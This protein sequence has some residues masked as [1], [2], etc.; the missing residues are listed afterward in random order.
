MQALARGRYTVERTLGSGGM[1]IVY[2]ARDEELGRPVAIKVLDE[3]FAADA[4]FRERFVR[5][6]R[7]A[8]RL[9]HPNIVRV[10]DVGEEDGQPYIVMEC[11][12]GTTLADE[13]TRRKHLPAHEVVELGLQACAGLAHAHGAGLVH[14]DVKPQN[15]L[16]RGDGVLKIA[17]FGI[18][19]AEEATRLTQ[20]GTVL[21]TVQ[22]LSPEQAAGEH[23]TAA[24]DLYSLGAVLYELLTGRPPRRFESLAELDSGRDEPIAPLGELAAD[25]SPELED[26]VMRSLARNPS[27]RPKSAAAFAQELGAASPEPATQPLPSASETRATRVLARPTAVAQQRRRRSRLAYWVAALAGAA[28]LVFGL[29]FLVGRELGD[30]PSPAPAVERVPPAGSPSERA[31][32]LADWIREH[33]R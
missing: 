3:R 32:N 29:A 19:R 25:V 12:E 27:Y 1:A 31:E 11:V 17:D 9:A 4:E 21:G 33:S 7:M 2:L 26:V 6:A 16:L 30:N 5:E 15:L 14:R 13:V 28:A 10:Y 20:V 18:A 24:A 22:Y 23:V 8:A